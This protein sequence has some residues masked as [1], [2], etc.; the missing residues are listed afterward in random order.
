M[1]IL[2]WRPTTVHLVNPTFDQREYDTNRF[3]LTYRGVKHTGG[4]SIATASL[5]TRR[6]SRDLKC[7]S[8]KLWRLSVS[9]RSL[10]SI[11]QA[12]ANESEIRERPLTR[13]YRVARALYVIIH[14]RTLFPF[15]EVYVGFVFRD[16]CG[17]GRTIS[18]ETYKDWT[19]IADKRNA[20]VS[21]SI[22]MLIPLYVSAKA[23]RQRMRRMGM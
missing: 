16:E 6:I 12:S 5:F 18:L 22:S 13:R 1:I 20:E 17:G 9:L 4:D 3:N 11:S 2:S 14:P 19:E 10:V 8:I 23:T 15:H 21:I 7:S